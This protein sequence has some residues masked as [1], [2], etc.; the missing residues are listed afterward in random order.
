MNAH[1]CVLIALAAVEIF[2]RRQTKWKANTA[3]VNQLL[4][5]AGITSNDAWFHDAIRE[6]ADKIDSEI[7][8]RKAGADEAA[9]WMFGPAGALMRNAMI[10]A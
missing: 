6:R 7:P 5:S 8:P 10:L 3:V 4:D 9:E 2:A 1:K